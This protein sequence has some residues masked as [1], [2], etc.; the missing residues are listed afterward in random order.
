M[1][2]EEV[3]SELNEIERK[4]NNELFKLSNFEDFK[5][6]V[7]IVESERTIGNRR[8]HEIQIKPILITKW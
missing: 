6:E 7:E 2:T 5:F 4:I 8:N 3:R 1:T